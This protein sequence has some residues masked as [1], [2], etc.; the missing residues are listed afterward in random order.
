M[1]VSVIGKVLLDFV[2]RTNEQRLFLTT[3]V[4]GGPYFRVVRPPPAGRLRPGIRYYTG[5]ALNPLV[6]LR[7]PSGVIPSG[8]AVRLELERPLAGAGNILT[9]ATFRDSTT[10]NGDPV[11]ARTSTLIFLERQFGQTLIPTQVE[12]FALFDDGEHEDGAMEPD[13]IFGFP[14]SELT[15]FEGNYT[16]RAVASYGGSCRGTREISWSLHVEIGIDPEMTT[17][18][19]QPVRPLPNGRHLIRVTFVPRDRYGNYLGPG[20]TNAFTLASGPGIVLSGPV[21]DAGDGSYAQD[22][23]WDPFVADFPCVLLSQPQRALAV[24]LQPGSMPETLIPRT[25]IWKYFD[26]GQDLGEAWRS[27]NFDDANWRTGPAQLGFGDGD[28]ATVIDGGSSTNRHA[29]IYFRKTFVVSDSSA[30]RSLLLRLLRAMMV[31]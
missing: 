28:E 26:R 8:A 7:Y 13:G 31:R 1:K 23:I 27:T 17:I 20:K 9:A 15:R 3:V 11:D 4:D 16:F 29:T 14:L 18:T 12:G 2:Q 6:L 21:G 22:V 5:D 10:A 24:K 25:S 19:A 30:C